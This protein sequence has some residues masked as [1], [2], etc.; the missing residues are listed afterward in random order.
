MPQF[1]ITAIFGGIGGLELGL[2][3]AG[4]RTSLFCEAD[5][6]AVTVLR[7]RFPK[8]PVALDV[9]HTDEL[10]ERISRKS[11]LL[12]AGFPC[13]DLSQAGTTRGFSGGRSSLIRETI[14][15]LRR[16]PF[17]N[18]LIENVPN[19]RHL[20]GG[21]YLR[22]VL[23]ALEDLGY[24]WAY[25]TIDARAFGLPQRRLRIFL[26]ATLK[27]DPRD[28]LFH[29]DVTPEQ[30]TIPLDEAA[31]GF[32][33]TEGTRGLGW[34]EDCVPTL[35]GGSAIGIPAPPA[36]LMPTMAIVTPD[37]VD[38]ERLQ[39]LS[40]GWTDF[41]E[42]DSLVGGGRFN[43]RRRWM[44][45]GNAVNVEVSGWIGKRLF[46]RKTF[47]GE[48]GE[49]LSAEDSWPAAAWFDGKVRRRVHL[50]TW[51]VNRKLKSLAGFLSKPGV[52]L[53]IRATAGFYKRINASRLSFKP[54]FV[55]AVGKH[56]RR[57]ERLTGS[58]ETKAKGPILTKAA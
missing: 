5:P 10:V 57:M 37:L 3:K 50:G 26:Y 49:V 28:V 22:E 20:H 30:R 40:A 44:L 47:S 38:V 18:V 42:R 6:D 17:P 29:G 11:N 46:D 24:R 21:E 25:R 27:G 7:Q 35:K 12:T 23:G 31:H 33:W 15:L 54:G 43:K 8:V 34:G 2:E 55:D 45:V 41:E 19:W 14:D 58:E 4:H 9:R 32:Y 16:R 48:P 56:L 53:S 13:T 36:I 51:P 1:D 39:G 52:P